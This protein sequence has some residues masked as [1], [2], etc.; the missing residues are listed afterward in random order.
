MT[1]TQS[2]DNKSADVRLRLEPELKVAVNEVLADVGLNLSDAIR[3]FLRQVVVYRGLPFE[4]RQPNAAT[5]RAVKEA[6]VM[7]N[8]R[9]GSVREML[10]ELEA[11]PRRKARRPPAAK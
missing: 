1:R 2:L 11:R 7:A 8:P 4:V 5:R 3:L 6:R 9:F 10:D